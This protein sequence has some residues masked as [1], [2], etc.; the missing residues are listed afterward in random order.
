MGNFLTTTG[1]ILTATDNMHLSGGD[2]FFNPPAEQG[3]QA[4]NALSIPRR[5]FSPIVSLMMGR[6]GAGKTL[7]MS[8]LAMMLAA[9]WHT[10]GVRRKIAANYYLDC[11]DYSTPYLL[12]ELMQFPEWASSALILIDEVQSAFP[13]R[14]S[15]AGSSVMFSNWL[16]Q[17]RKFG[18]ELC[19]TTQFA[20]VIDQQLLL[21]CDLFI[22][23]E[24]R[25][26][27]HSVRL[28]IWDWWGQWT[29][30]MY[31]KPFPPTIGTHDWTMDLMN[32]NLIWPHYDT[33]Q[34]QPAL[35]AKN[36]EALLDRQWDANPPGDGGGVYD[37]DGLR[38][39]AA[40]GAKPPTLEDFLEMASGVNGSLNVPDSFSEAKR[41]FKI[42]TLPHFEEAIRKAGYKIT[43]EGNY[44]GAYKA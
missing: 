37:L 17:I 13:G 41:L 19:F 3:L 16:T 24:N 38:A 20:G 42:K 34:F 10:N 23:C 8:Y 4:I 44:W 7:S 28:F 29:G 2:S 18:V 33:N 1:G 43:H 31:R 27:G 9:N 30:K 35:W 21:Q 25:G 22:L 15:L 11:A 5:R 32:A 36:R 26:G 39:G 14:R 40:V 6:R 12:D